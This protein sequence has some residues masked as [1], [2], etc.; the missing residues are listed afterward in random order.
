[1]GGAVTVALCG[2]WDHEGPCRWPHHT[3]AQAADDGTRRVIVR[4]D[5]SEDDHAVV[6]DRVD[7][8]LQSTAQAGPHGQVSR[9]SLVATRS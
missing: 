2:H 9:W 5:S 1:M 4:F 3:E 7:G 6:S 8:A